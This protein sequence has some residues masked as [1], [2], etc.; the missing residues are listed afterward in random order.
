MGLLAPQFRRGVDVS[1]AAGLHK[2]KAYDHSCYARRLLQ[3]VIEQS[4]KGRGVLGGVSPNLQ[5]A[6]SL[7]GPDYSLENF[8]GLVQ[9][10]C[11][12][13]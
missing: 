9:E 8:S 13:L 3:I 4:M 12:C 7:I 5:P 10:A 11:V 1:L 2:E 6:K